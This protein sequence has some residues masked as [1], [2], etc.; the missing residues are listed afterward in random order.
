MDQEIAKILKAAMYPGLAADV[1]KPWKKSDL[2]IIKRAND[3]KGM[4]M[5]KEA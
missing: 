3:Q 5:Y 1:P 4:G 2:D